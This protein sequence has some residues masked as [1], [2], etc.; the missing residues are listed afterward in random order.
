ARRDQHAEID[1]ARLELVQ[2]VQPDLGHLLAGQRTKA[3][4]G[5]TPLDRHLAAFEADLVIAAR[6][7]LLSLD[8]AAGGLA[9]A[10]ALP[11]T[12]PLAVLRGAFG[13]MQCVQVHFSSP[14]PAT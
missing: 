3:P 12:D 5:K 4:L 9:Q 6:A 11:A 14:R 2:L 13:W 10:G 1:I 7:G 8:A